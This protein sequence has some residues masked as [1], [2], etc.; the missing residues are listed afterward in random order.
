VHIVPRWQNDGAGSVHTIFPRK[1][2]REIKDVG[3]LIRAAVAEASSGID[4]GRGG[5]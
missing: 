4:V 5:D 1:A 3:T 2:Y